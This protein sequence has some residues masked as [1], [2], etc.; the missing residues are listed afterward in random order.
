MQVP[1]ANG[2][3]ALRCVLLPNQHG[4]GCSGHHLGTE[5][6]LRGNRER[7]GVGRTILRRIVFC[8]HRP[9]GLLR[10]DAGDLHP[11]RVT[12]IVCSGAPVTGPLHHCL[13]WA[14]C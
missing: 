9:A 11:A 14:A 1:A 13:M 7:P 10:H 5:L 3:A 12:S 8:A 4:S 2:F 6:L